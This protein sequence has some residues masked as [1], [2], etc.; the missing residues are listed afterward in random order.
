MNM[1]GHQI[2]LRNIM[3]IAAGLNI[4]INILLIPGYGIYG[5]AVAAMS[6]LMCWNITTLVYMKMKFGKTTGYFPIAEFL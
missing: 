2:V 3:L 1:T 4:G 5:A 6:S